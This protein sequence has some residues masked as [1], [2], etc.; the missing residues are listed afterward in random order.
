VLGLLMPF[1]AL[2]ATSYTSDSSV[3]F[4]V[5]GT[6]GD[7]AHFDL[8]SGNFFTV[9][10]NYGQD[11]YDLIYQKV[12]HEGSDL[13]VTRTLSSRSFE[14]LTKEEIELLV[15]GSNIGTFLTQD[16]LGAGLTP[17]QV[18]ARQAALV[19]TLSDEK[20][21]ADL[22][23]VATL[24][25]RSTEIFSDGDE[26]NSGFDL[27][28]DLT[29]I[30]GLLF[31]ETQGL[32]GTPGPADNAGGNQVSLNTPAE[33]GARPDRL[34]AVQPDPANP[35]GQSQRPLAQGSGA[36]AG[37]RPGSQ[38]SAPLPELVSDGL[39]CPVDQDFNSAVESVRRQEVVA[40][41]GAGGSPRA[42]DDGGAVAGSAGSGGAR[43]TN[44]GSTSTVEQGLSPQRIELSPAQAGSWKRPLPCNEFFC[45][46]I[47]AKYKTETSYTATENSV[48]SH[49]Q[50]INDSFKKTLDRDL[51]PNKVTGNLLEGPKC[52]KDIAGAEW[53]TFNLITIPAPIL[54]PPNDDVV[55]KGDIIS[56][57]IDFYEKYEPFGIGTQRG[58]CE[59]GEI[60]G[61]CLSEEPAAAKP[62][63][64]DTAKQALEQVAE[65][66]TLEQINRRI[67][68]EVEAKRTQAEQLLSQSRL[69][70]DARNQATQFNVL[71][72]EL[73]TMNAFFESF[74]ELFESIQTPC[75]VLENKPV[76]S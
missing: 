33:D 74:R 7:G 26:S 12:R 67:T 3:A 75:N 54:T 22:E 39:L 10:D 53:L 32:S 48:V 29:I 47:E 28:T 51:V 9:D 63:Q 27:I 49:V 19:T 55:T 41:N 61:A 44:E 73:D 69:D 13:A 57:M 35:F 52:K 24:E 14:G 60:G 23:A 46:R 15:P 17:Q 71:M 11:L 4:G 70:A 43:P 68:D 1:V 30:E 42:Q 59:N 56:N 2:A 37:T 8:S 18:Q 16:K 66:T 58:R 31:G 36:A 38:G 72:V 62:Q 76:C 21:L 65:G 25:V 45:L 34:V 64:L 6:T 5:L 20:E 40:Q 50:H